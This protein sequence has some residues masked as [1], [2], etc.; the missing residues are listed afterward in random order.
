MSPRAPRA[1][2][3]VAPAAGSPFD[4]GDA[5][6]LSRSGVRRPGRVA[7]VVGLLILVAVIAWHLPRIPDSL[8]LA[9]AAV[10][11]LTGWLLSR[12]RV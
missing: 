12:R 2:R 3:S 7:L 4:E 1:V 8:V 9:A 6:L 5:A 10:V 11:A